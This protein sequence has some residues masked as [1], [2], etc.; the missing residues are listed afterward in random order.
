MGT[1]RWEKEN[2]EGAKELQRR[3]DFDQ[4]RKSLELAEAN[5]RAR[6]KIL[7]HDLQRQRAE[8]ALYSSDDEARIASSSERDE[9]LRR[10]R[11]A[12]PAARANGAAVAPDKPRATNG[13]AKAGRRN[14]TEARDGS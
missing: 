7:E 11:S 13:T 1:L 12:D 6:I 8:L 14:K 4:K 9:A 3:S 2:E 10:I 5:S